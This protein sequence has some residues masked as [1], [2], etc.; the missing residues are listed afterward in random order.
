MTLDPLVLGARRQRGRRAFVGHSFADRAAE[1]VRVPL[2]SLVSLALLVSRAEAQL[3]T[4]GAGQFG[5]LHEALVCTIHM[6]HLQSGHHPPPHK[7]H[8]QG[9]VHR[10][11]RGLLHLRAFPADAESQTLQQGSTSA[12]QS[13]QSGLY[14][15][16][17]SGVGRR[18]LAS[19]IGKSGESNWVGCSVRS[20]SA[21][22]E[23]RHENIR[24]FRRARE[25]GLSSIALRISTAHCSCRQM[26]LVR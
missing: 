12:T 19:E 8:S 20:P 10:C 2:Q 9:S 7:S 1:T 25:M 23:P 17:V 22:G 5:D 15:S 4:I 24:T 3:A 14:L 11:R 21:V 13:H 26:N 18:A 16:G 6:M